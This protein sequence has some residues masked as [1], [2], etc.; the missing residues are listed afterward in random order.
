[1]FPYGDDG[2]MYRARRMEEA[3]KERL[4]RLVQVKKEPGKSIFSRLFTWR[5]SRKNEASRTPAREL[6]P[7]SR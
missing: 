3:Q 1:M 5:G 7:S 6:L 4:Y 2:E